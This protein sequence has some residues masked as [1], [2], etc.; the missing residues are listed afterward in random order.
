MRH[1]PRAIPGS[2]TAVLHL[3]ETH[4]RGRSEYSTSSQFR[5]ITQAPLIG[6]V[7]KVLAS[8]LRNRLMDDAL[9]RL[10]HGTSLLLQVY[11]WQVTI[12]RQVVFPGLILCCMLGNV[13]Q[14]NSL[15]FK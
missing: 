4:L 15:E 11:K 5:L 13:L 6:S 2:K 1:D 9:R 12:G 3:A 7:M 10:G 8:V 14:H